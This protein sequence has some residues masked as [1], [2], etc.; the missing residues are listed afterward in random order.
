GC[1]FSLPRQNQINSG[2]LRPPKTGVSGWTQIKKV[3]SSVP[4]YSAWRAAMRKAERGGYQFRVPKFS[5]RNPHNIPDYGL[6][7]AIEG[8]SLK[9][10]QE[11]NLDEYY[12]LDEKANAVRYFLPVKLTKVCLYCHGDP[13]NAPAYWGRNDGTDPTGVAM[14]NWQ[15]GEMHGAF[16]VVQSLDEADKALFKSL[17]QGG[18]ISLVGIL[19]AASIFFFTA[20]S[21]TKPLESGVKLAQQMAHGDFSQRLKLE[22]H[23]EVGALT[24]AMNQMAIDLGKIFS[25][26]QAGIEILFKSSQEL[27][28]ISGQMSNEAGETS[29]RSNSVASAAE[30]MSTNMASVTQAMASSADNINQVAASTEEMTG[31]I[32]EIADST[33]RART[34]VGNAVAKVSQASVSI[35]RLGAS[36]EEI[37]KVTE[38]IT[39]I[40]EQTN[41]LALNATIEAA[42]AGEAGKGFAVVANEIKELS[43]QTAEATL[44]IQKKINGIQESSRITVSDIKIIEKVVNDVREIV[45][46]IATAIEEQTGNVRT[47]SSNLEETSHGIVE[48]NENVAQSNQAAGEI[49]QDIAMVNNSAREISTN[50][51]DVN[52]SAERLAGLAAELN[53]LVN[54]IKI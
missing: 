40:S 37:G 9:K 8:P 25:E 51:N 33:D 5:P 31:T 30:E 16:E 4:V 39:E 26:I 53:K 18:I 38:S 2:G 11:E 24:A 23:D 47:I 13:A 32:N 42:R 1:N 43:K 50:S 19:L 17:F 35:G 27:T 15:V 14:E 54:R 20:R 34:I 3:I 36:A 52:Q 29:A 10:L 6:D 45:D 44:E 28:E 48:V 41:L 49:A 21:I 7:Y 22:Q 12:I 46:I